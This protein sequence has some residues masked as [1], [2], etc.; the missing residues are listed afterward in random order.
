MERLIVAVAIIGVVAVVSVIVR[1]RRTP[2]APTQRRFTAPTQLDRT[3]F[4][5]P[6]APWLVVVFTSATC[7]VCHSVLAKA[8][9]L[10]SDDV[11]VQEVEYGADRATP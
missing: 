5:R 3:E 9:V 6:Q 2:D 8:D 7:E 10:A 4:V 1:R 11:A